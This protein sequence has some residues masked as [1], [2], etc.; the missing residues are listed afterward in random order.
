MHPVSMY[1][2]AYI[3]H[4]PKVDLDLLLSS[5]ALLSC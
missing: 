5:L 1:R 2:Y 4:T 3:S